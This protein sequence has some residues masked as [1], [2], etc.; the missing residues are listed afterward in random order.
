VR[1]ASRAAWGSEIA[2]DGSGVLYRVGG[3]LGAPVR[4]Y[5]SPWHTTRD[6]F[7]VGAGWDP[8]AVFVR[9]RLLVAA[10]PIVAADRG[11]TPDRTIDALVA[12]SV[13]GSPTRAISAPADAASGIHRATD[14]DMAA[15]DDGAVVAW[16]EPE[17]TDPDSPGRRL[18]VA[19]IACE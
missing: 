18:A 8:S 16:I 13:P 15:T 19:R 10:V 14:F 2:R 5:Y 11:D 4:L 9:G 7:A 12:A 17:G 1:V 3:E 6:P